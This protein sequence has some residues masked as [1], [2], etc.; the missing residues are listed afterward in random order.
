MSPK[1]FRSLVMTVFVQVK[2]YLKKPSQQPALL[3]AR[4]ATGG[5]LVTSA[6]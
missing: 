3:P 6:R 4:V 2:Q 5:A 1:N